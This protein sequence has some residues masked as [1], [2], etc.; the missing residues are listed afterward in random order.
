MNQILNKC[1]TCINSRGII[2]ENGL[3]YICSLSSHKAIECM[4]DEKNYYI[5]F[6]TNTTK[7][8]DAN[9]H[10]NKT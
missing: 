2:S 4:F 7:K 9:E 1:N 6:R 10:K 3:H 8:D 5:N